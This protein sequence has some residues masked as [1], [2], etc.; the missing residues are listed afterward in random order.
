[1]LQSMGSQRVDMTWQL[2]NCAKTLDPQKPHLLVLVPEPWSLLFKQRFHLENITWKYYIL[3]IGE[4]MDANL[5]WDPSVANNKAHG[6]Y[7]HTYMYT[8][9]KENGTGCI[10]LQSPVANKERAENATNVYKILETAME[11]KVK[12]LLSVY[13]KWIGLSLLLSACGLSLISTSTSVC[14]STSWLAFF[15]DSWPKSQTQS[16]RHWLDFS[17]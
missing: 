13:L 9:T 5:S 14:I 2:N 8:H 15:P 6:N 16:S 7:I 12:V 3:K 1:M 10:Y 4:I 17:L 11:S